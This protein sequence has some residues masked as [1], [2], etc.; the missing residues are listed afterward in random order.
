M[1]LCPRTFF[2]K[3]DKVRFKTR[4]SKN[5]LAFGADLGHIKY[6]EKSK[7]IVYK[8]E[9]R[10]LGKLN[11]LIEKYNNKSAKLG[12]APLEFSIK[13]LSIF[14]NE[15][16]RKHLE[17]SFTGD[18]ARIDGWEF[19]G[20]IQ[21]AETGNIL[22]SVPGKEIS[23]AFRNVKP[24]CEHCAKYRA[25]KDTFILTKEDV[26]KQVG[27]NCLR[28][29]L[30]HDPSTALALIDMIRQLSE[31]SEGHYPRM[32]QPIEL[33]EMVA[34]M[35][36]K[37]GFSKDTPPLAWNYLFM[38]PKLAKQIR[39]GSMPHITVDA[40]AQKTAKLAIEWLATAEMNSFL[41]NVKTASTMPCITQ[42]E[43]TLAAWTVGA[44]LKAVES[45]KLAQTKAQLR[46]EELLKN[47]AIGKESKHLGVVGERLELTLK[48]V[49]SR[50]MGPGFYNGTTILYKFI[51]KEGSY[52]TWFT[53]SNLELEEGD[54]IVVKATIKEHKVY[55]EVCET[56]VT[57]LT[58]ISQNEAQAG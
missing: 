21:H 33:L 54:Q 2:S 52:V 23:E 55:Q 9:Y 5:L 50:K 39:E 28:D 17:V 1:R 27:R 4:Q 7:P 34:A 57:R 42:R 45:D 12:T 19:L 16:E 22:R 32:V 49:L 26:T 18:P 35:A 8:I 24:H 14:K 47:K 6:M 51:T 15:I 3:R 46:R 11:S 10:A 29:F 43:S 40:E 30:G 53:G 31:E 41:S 36:N 58:V 20:T 25:R 44:Y 48:L 56:A 13:T 38:G 37:I